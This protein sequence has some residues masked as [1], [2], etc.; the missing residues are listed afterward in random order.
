MIISLPVTTVIA[1][2]ATASPAASMA[3][4]P[5][6]AGDAAAEARAKDW[7]HQVQVGKIDRSQL[8]AKMNSALTDSLLAQVSGQLGPLGE[9]T[10]F[11][12]SRKVTQGSI[13]A[14]VY[15]VVF[16]Q[17]TLAE[18]IAFDPDGKIGG[19]LFKPWSDSQ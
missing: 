10:S 17:I 6:P 14:Y 8:D 2:A 13:T 5:V 18:T 3:P 7:L 16:P 12:Q 15:K 11:T 19:L 4:A 1:Q 9:P